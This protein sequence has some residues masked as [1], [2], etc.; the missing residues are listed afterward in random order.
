ME[1]DIN[2]LTTCKMTSFSGKWKMTL[3]M[4]DEPNILLNGRP[5]HFLLGNAGLINFL[6]HGTA[7]P[8]HVFFIFGC[9]V[10]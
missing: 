5:H 1:N 2:Y 7:Q 8:Q 10:E 9:P 4:E 6:E 3:V